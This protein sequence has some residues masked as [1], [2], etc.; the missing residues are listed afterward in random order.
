MAKMI[1]EDAQLLEKS[2]SGRNQYTLCLD[3]MPRVFLGNHERIHGKKKLFL[4]SSEAMESLESFIDM[5]NIT[6]NDAAEDIA[7]ERFFEKLSLYKGK[8]GDV[9]IILEPCSKWL[10]K[11]LWKVFIE[12]PECVSKDLTIPFDAQRPSISLYPFPG[13]EKKVFF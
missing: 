6:V 12:I 10:L 13:S 8:S 5:M 4:I 1:A 2:G 9:A 3:N 11:G 7:V